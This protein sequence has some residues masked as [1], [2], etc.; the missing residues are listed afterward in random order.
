MHGHIT[1]NIDWIDFKNGKIINGGNK[2]RTLMQDLGYGDPSSNNFTATYRY[3]TSDRRL[4]RVHPPNTVNIA[5]WGAPKADPNNPQ[6]ADRHLAWAINRAAELYRQRNLDWAYVDIPDTYYYQHTVKLRDGVK[7]RGAGPDRNVP[8]QSW[9]TN[10][11][12][13]MMP[14]KAMYMHKSSFDPVAEHDER[15]VMTS[16]NQWTLTNEYL[17]SKIGIQD[18]KINGN[19]S[20]NQ[21]VFENQGEYDNLITLLQN[22]SNW[23]AWYTTGSGGFTY[24]EDMRLEINRVHSVEMGGNNFAGGG[25]DIDG[26]R[27]A[28]FKVYSED[29]RLRDAQRNHQVYGMPGP[30]KENWSVVGQSWAGPMKI[31]SRNNR[32]STYT[33]LTVVPEANEYF[34]NVG[35]VSTLGSNVTID[36]FEID[37]QSS[38]GDGARGHIF[39]DS[40]GGNVFKNGTIKTYSKN[41][42]TLTNSNAERMPTEFRNIDVEDYGGGIAIRSKGRDYNHFLINVSVVP[43]G[44]YEP[45]R[46]GFA[47]GNLSFLIGTTLEKP[48][49]SFNNGA[50]SNLEKAKREE[51][52]SF[53]YQRQINTNFLTVAGGDGTYN[54]PWHPEDFWFV[55]SDFAN[56]K[57]FDR[58]FL[59]WK[60]FEN[61]L[62]NRAIRMYWDNVT[63]NTL[64]KSSETFHERL[65]PGGSFR[66]RNSQDRSGRTS[67]ASGTYTSNT[68]DEGNDFVLIETSLISRAWDRDATVT[69]GAPTV[70]SVKIANSDGTLRADDDIREEDPYLKVNL[71][72]AIGTG[73]TIDVDWTARVT[74]L[75]DYQ[76]TG[77]FVSR[78]VADMTLTA[79]NGPWTEDLRGVAASQESREKIIYTASSNDTSVVTAS[80][81]ADDFTLELTEQGTGTATITVTGTIDGVGTTTDTFQVTV[82]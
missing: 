39:L 6:R 32:S 73:E 5:W 53:S 40:N 71:D 12:L 59:D 57:Q 70:Q 8:E 77:L 66:I 9:T 15:M 60:R 56:V 13:R 67:E 45:L 80:V 29:V 10:G 33:N 72:Q 23:S 31:G 22:A 35:V 2:L 61:D 44:E 64:T 47:G 49:T 25:V 21:Q 4:E 26:A 58:D 51:Y 36:G 82:E 68:G 48:K 20:N 3:A 34:N 50:K 79:G 18:L 52:R 14:G 75:D 19:L 16:G 41:P 78:P 38:D 42:I 24:E 65:R 28:A 62:K 76:T 55:D 7:L 81:N 30:K 43:Q 46:P 63:Y 54:G 17:A 1:K 27:G 74:P 11:E 37:L 69:S